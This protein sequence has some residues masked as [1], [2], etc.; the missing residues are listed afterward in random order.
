MNIQ[1]IEVRINIFKIDLNYPMYM[2]P[3]FEFLVELI[4]S[5]KPSEKR[6]FKKF[7]QFWGGNKP[8]YVILFDLIDAGLKQKTTHPQRIFV[9]VSRHEE[10]KDLDNLSRFL[11]DKILEA[12]RATQHYAPKEKEL[13]ALI[14]DINFLVQKEFYEASLDYIKRA[15]RIAIEIERL[16]YL[17]DLIFYERSI[18]IRGRLDQNGKRMNAL[19]Q[20]EKEVLESLALRSKFQTAAIF[21]SNKHK[22]DYRGNW[23]PDLPKSSVPAESSMLFWTNLYHAQYQT[24]L[25]LQHI[26][27]N[28]G[29]NLRE[30]PI[31]VLNEI[32]E[33][34]YKVYQMY[35]SMSFMKEEDPGMY[36]LVIDRFLTICLH[37][38]KDQFFKH[39]DK[40]NNG[41]KYAN[42]NVI[43]YRNISYLYLVNFIKNIKFEEAKA[44]IE[45][46]SLFEKIQ[47]Y[48]LKIP[49]YRLSVLVANCAEVYF[50]TEDFKKVHQWIY[51]K[52]YQ[53][54]QTPFF[55]DVLLKAMGFIAKI[56]LGLYGKERFESKE[57][58]SFRKTIE[59]SDRHDAEHIAL[60]LMFESAMYC[61]TRISLRD[62]LKP[63]WENIQKIQNFKNSTNAL[64]YCWVESRVK[65]Q[66]LISTFPTYK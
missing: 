18:L 8:K 49:N 52:H 29:L 55:P 47:E 16:N 59:K 34:E 50:V 45:E 5:L 22:M 7:I 9:T 26:Q 15:R 39:V 6:D 33:N 23:A 42:K 43:F 56:E 32:F 54:P 1:K 48:Y 51:H 30:V 11:I 28:G 36:W 53:S 3:I 21:L 65:E 2:T 60:V 27:P 66:S 20:E 38:N 63:Y 19:D 31:E 57:I 44:F 14:R 41:F 25:H 35:E 4:G 24:A 40:L 37:L 61:Q 10:L 62:V 58:Q 12:M 64:I 13:N 17:L 46:H